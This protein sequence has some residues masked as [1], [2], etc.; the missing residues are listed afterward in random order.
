M[1]L[2][3]HTVHF[4]AVASTTVSARCA[5]TPRACYAIRTV[6]WVWRLTFWR[7]NYFF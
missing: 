1:L 4:I 6:S 3:V 5:G 2:T 7:R